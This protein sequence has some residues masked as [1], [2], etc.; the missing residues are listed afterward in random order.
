MKSAAAALTLLALTLG[1]CAWK[2]SFEPFRAPPPPPPSAV[3]RIVVEPG[4]QVVEVP[5]DPIETVIEGMSQAQQVRTLTR[6]LA[7]GK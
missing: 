5:L 7:R 6:Q 1:G 2:A 3:H 4:G